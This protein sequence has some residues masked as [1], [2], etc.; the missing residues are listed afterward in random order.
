MVDKKHIRGVSI[1]FSSSTWKYH[2][3]RYGCLGNVSI[4]FSSSTQLNLR[5][6]VKSI[7][8]SFHPLFI[9]HIEENAIED[10][11]APKFPSSFHRALG[12]EGEKL[13]GSEKHVSILF[14]SS[15]MLLAL[16]TIQTYLMR[17]HPL[18]IEHLTRS[19]ASP[20]ST[21]SSF[22]PLFIEH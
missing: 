12:C 21:R 16:Y 22:H 18:F 7:L 2:G 10:A 3:H 19:S 17:F 9:E 4:L 15:T 5:G 13:W 6:P 8:L 20:W 14:S 11:D 1:L